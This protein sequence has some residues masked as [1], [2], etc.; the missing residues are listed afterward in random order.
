[1]QE[2]RPNSL[3]LRIY[4]LGALR[5]AGAALPLVGF[6]GRALAHNFSRSFV[7]ARPTEEAAGFYD[8]AAQFASLA[9]QAAHGTTNQTGALLAQAV[10]HLAKGL[11]RTNTGL[12]ATYIL[13]EQIKDALHRQGH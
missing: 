8:M 6:G 7:M 2:S 11:Q 13:L 4:V 12:R 1:M 5:A 9:E 3:A 10:N